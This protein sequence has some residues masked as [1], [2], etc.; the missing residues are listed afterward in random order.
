MI[1]E[2]D[3]DQQQ[4]TVRSAKAATG[5]TGRTVSGK[6]L[7]GVAR[8]DDFP[9]QGGRRTF[10]RHLSVCNFTADTMG[11]LPRPSERRASAASPN[12]SKLSARGCTAV[13][14]RVPDRKKSCSRAA[15][16]IVEQ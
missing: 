1:K 13:G 11:A 6:R 9:S 15:A 7:L 10:P 8:G 5:R 14:S 12:F 3:D 4:H 16:L 2:A